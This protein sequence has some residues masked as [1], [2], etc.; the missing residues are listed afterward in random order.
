VGRTRYP[1]ISLETALQSSKIVHSRSDGTAKSRLLTDTFSQTRR[2]RPTQI[3]RNPKQIHLTK[4]DQ[5]DLQ[6]AKQPP[7][8][9]AAGIIRIAANTF[10]GLNHRLLPF[11]F[12]RP[13]T[14]WCA[15]FQSTGSTEAQIFESPASLKSGG[16][17]WRVS[18][19]YHQ[20]TKAN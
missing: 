6:G 15:D 7:P 4:Y 9:I 1:R 5:R 8:A 13:Q 18:K 17:E 10:G 11:G 14:G 16:F 20:H 3:T 2:T 19:R 12:A